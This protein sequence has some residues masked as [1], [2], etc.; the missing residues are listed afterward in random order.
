MKTKIQSKDN[1]MKSCEICQ[2]QLNVRSHHIVPITFNGTD[3]TNNRI[4]I[5][6]YCHA[7]LHSFYAN[8]A[9]KQAQDKL[10]NKFFFDCIEIFKNQISSPQSPPKK[11]KKQFSTTETA[12]E[13]GYTRAYIWMLIKAKKLKAKKVGET[14]IIDKKELERYKLEIK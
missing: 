2:G 13:L 6:G 10:G 9:I 7:Q 3:S 14:Y 1:T 4:D 5:C 12:K 8:I 11:K